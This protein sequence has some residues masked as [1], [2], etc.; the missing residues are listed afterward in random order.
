MEIAGELASAEGLS[1]IAGHQLCLGAREI[2]Q[3][4]GGRQ[5]AVSAAALAGINKGPGFL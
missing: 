1:D 5:D 2:F 4:T 3:L